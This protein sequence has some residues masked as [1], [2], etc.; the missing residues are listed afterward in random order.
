VKD[1]S[2]Y[3]NVCV[4]SEQLLN[5]FALRDGNDMDNITKNGSIIT[6]NYPY[7]EFPLWRYLLRHKN[8]N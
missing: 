7:T 4:T 5:L 1:L 8:T 6:D 3:D 2:E